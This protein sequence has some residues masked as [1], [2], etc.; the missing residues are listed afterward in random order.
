MYISDLQP[1]MNRVIIDADISE[2]GPIREFNKFGKPGKVCDAKIKDKTGEYKLVL[3]NEECDTIN[4]GDKIR[5]ING[6]T[7]RYQGEP[8]L[9]I[10]QY[11]KYE[12]LKDEE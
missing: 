7:K 12:I 3:W 11:G 1:G 2:K 4:V 10:G 8:Q 5:I 6:Y 9:N